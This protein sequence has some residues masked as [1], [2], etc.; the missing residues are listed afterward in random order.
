MYKEIVIN[1]FDFMF[2]NSN[3]LIKKLFIPIIL[4]STIIYLI[5][6]FI[7]PEIVKFDINS[8]HITSLI[9]P[10]VLA[11]FLIMLNISIAITTHRLAILGKDFLPSFSSII[12][13]LREFKFLL[14]TILMGIIIAIPTILAIFI[15]YVGP[16][17]AIFVAILLIS[18]LAL[19]FPSISCDEPISFY[20]SWKFSKNHTLLSLFAIIIFPIIFSLTVGIIYTLVIEFMIKSIS[21]HF[22]ILYSLLN[23][24]IIVFSISALSSLFIYLKPTPLNKFKKDESERMRDIVEKEK[25]I[26]LR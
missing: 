16:F 10:I 23:V 5:P 15:P 25:K 13:G 12:L 1:T 21:P 17:I 9:I 4:I 22:S 14:K 11:F 18:R 20:S 26:F 6:Q 19:V 3:Q 7:N 2:K 24:F 8:L